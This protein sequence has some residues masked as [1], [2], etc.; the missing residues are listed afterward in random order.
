MVSRAHSF[1]WAGENGTLPTADDPS[2]SFMHH[3]MN[4]ALTTPLGTPAEFPSNPVIP[5]AF[6]TGYNGK[7]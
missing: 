7:I 6:L 2:H 1:G 5:G 3:R 4:P